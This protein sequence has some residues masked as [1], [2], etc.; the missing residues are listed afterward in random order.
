MN[1]AERS[2]ALSL[3]VG[4][5]GT[6]L[7]EEEKRFLNKISPLGVILFKRN[8]KDPQQLLTLTEEIKRCC[9]RE[10]VIICVD[11]EGGRVQRFTEPFTII[12]PAE[13]VGRSDNEYLATELGRIIAT[14]LLACGVNMNLAPVCDINT[15]PENRVIADRAY[16]QNADIVMRMSESFM[17][18]LIQGGVKCCAKHF[19]GH[20]D[21]SIDSHESLPVSGKGLEELY[22][23][24]LLPFINII[25]KGVESIMLAHI[26]FENIDPDLPASLSEKFVSLLRNELAF[27]GIIMTD[28]LEMKSITKQYSVADAALKAI[29]NGVDVVLVCHTPQYQIETFEKI[30]RYY[31]DNPEKVERKLERIQGLLSGLTDERPDLSLIGCERHKE[32]VKEIIELSKE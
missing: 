32:L 18:G 22:E 15:N 16:G 13:V 9:E 23:R 14:E 3:I 26:L 10:D 8:Y 30:K 19:P 7:L 31:L 20:G 4:I 11:Q 2:A 24:E 21:T 25:E 17:N 28:D 27:D 1:E 5:S 12:P 29:Q 6:S